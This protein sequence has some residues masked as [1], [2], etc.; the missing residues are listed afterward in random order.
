MIRSRSRQLIRSGIGRN[1]QCVSIQ[2]T[3]ST[4]SRSSRNASTSSNAIPKLK[5]D[6]SFGNL[7]GGAAL[8]AGICLLA[9][10]LLSQDSQKD[11][12]KGAVQKLIQ[13]ISG[14][15]ETKFGKP[16]LTGYLDILRSK[17]G[18]QEDQISLEESEL[19]SHGH[20]PWSYHPAR[21]PSAVI[22]PST[23]EQVQELVK[24]APK[25]GVVLTPYAGG[26]SLEAHWAAP[27]D[28]PGLQRKVV[29]VDFNLMD[30]IGECNVA[31][32]DIEVE[33]GVKYEDLNEHLLDQGIDLF[34]PVDPGPGAALG[35]MMGTGGS[36]TNA[37][38]YG[39]MRGDYI[40][41][42]TVVLP[43]GELITTRS[44]SRKSSV[45]PD[46]TKIFL[47]AEGT[48][49][50]VVKARLR[51][52]PLLPTSIV[53]VPFP[54]IHDACSAAQQIVQGG[55]GVQCIELLDD[56]MIR[57]I[58]TA[59]AKSAGDSGYK[60]HIVKPSLFIKLQ[61]NSSHR[62]EDERVVRQISKTLGVK[63]REIESS[64][65]SEA[66][67][68]LWR[69]RKIALWSC[70]EAMPTRPE[71]KDNEQGKNGYKV[72]TTDVSVPLGS[73]ADLFTKVRKD[74]QDSG[75]HAP[76]IGHIGDGGAHSIIVF[77]DEDEQEL[78]KVKAFVHRI[79]EY[80]HE[81]EGTC[82]SEHG[83]GRGKRMYLER[84]LGKGT[85]E[86]L[87]RIKK[88]LD[89]HNIMNPGSLLY[90]TDQERQDELEELEALS[91]H[92]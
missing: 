7:F 9:I 13:N 77:K 57:V 91:K 40:I 12:G 85:V 76:I 26:T 10:E 72:W 46:L 32:G 56:E 58:N 42:A 2:S 73:M 30:K 22:Y 54:S 21:S 36:G 37:V 64:H 31:D 15:G 61:G 41:N 24:Q 38:R 29:S 4:V 44:R 63:D 45:G 88:A 28:H 66:N 50:L 43:N 18:F 8:G 90:E 23:V 47:G 86:L 48:M 89:P 59:N 71:F 55:V 25:H 92:H 65:E 11:G 5:N 84:E 75:L 60:E 14:E 69:A 52:A 70:L 19:E 49:G 1:A 6:S 17:A 78:N 81:M 39:T 27:P 3:L 20:S 79:V 16:N 62:K 82:T 33:A 87:Q 35:G 53:V 51:L 74:T 67:E 34:F 68:R 80:A 83:I